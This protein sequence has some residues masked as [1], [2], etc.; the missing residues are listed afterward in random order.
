MST[1]ERM[2]KY[3]ARQALRAALERCERLGV[4]VA[5]IL[6]EQRERQR[7]RVRR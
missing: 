2:R 4:D 7:D 6:A 1:A 3:R 5:A